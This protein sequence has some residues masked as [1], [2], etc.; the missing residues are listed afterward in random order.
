MVELKTMLSK[1]AVVFLCF[2]GGY[3]AIPGH[4]AF[5]TNSVAR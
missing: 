1:A 5:E 2:S 3:C 4:N